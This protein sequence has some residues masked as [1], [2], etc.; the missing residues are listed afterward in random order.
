MFRQASAF[1]QPL[2]LDTSSV[3]NMKYVPPPGACVSNGPLGRG[4][5]ALPSATILYTS[6]VVVH[7]S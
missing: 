6:C 3:T 7:N 1:N 5:W 2:N 4:A